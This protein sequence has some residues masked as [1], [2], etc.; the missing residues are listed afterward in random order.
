MT[1]ISSALTTAIN[2]ALLAELG[3]QMGK[4][5]NFGQ[6]NITPGII[7]GGLLTQLMRNVNVTCLPDKIPAKLE[8]DVSDMGIGDVK[9]VADI[10][11]PA[12]VKATSTHDEAVAAVIAPEEVKETTAAPG[13]EGAAAAGA[14]PAAGAAAAPAAGGK[15]AAPAAGGKA[16]APAAKADPKKK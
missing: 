15:A 16:A 9:H 3:A 13:A 11:M 4:F 5:M 10:K 2:S 6:M 1:S 12:D 14:A 7:D 8:L